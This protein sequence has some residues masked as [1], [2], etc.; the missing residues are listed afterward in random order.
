MNPRPH[1]CIA[2]RRRFLRAA[3]LACLGL[4]IAPRAWAAAPRSI[5]LYH[6]HT[7][8]RLSVVYFE[9]GAYLRDA[10]ASINALLRDF[11]TGDAAEID[12]RLFDTLHALNLACGA[13]TFEV[14]SAYRS[15]RTNEMLRGRSHG[16][17]KNSLHTQ[18]RAIDVRLA[19]CDTRTLRDAAIALAAGGVGYYAASDF[20]HLDTGRFRA[21]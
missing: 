19:G 8:E 18:G 12:P 10:L 2:P 6:T 1:S 3:G 11:R 21:W 20:V 9:R 13:G 5:S 15:P 16:V 17:A 4:S 7:G 14:I